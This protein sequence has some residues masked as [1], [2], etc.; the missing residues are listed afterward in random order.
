[1]ALPR[2]GR[3][4]NVAANSSPLHVVRSKAETTGACCDPTAGPT[5][6][7]RMWR[8]ALGYLDSRVI[9]DRA[10]ALQAQ[11]RSAH[12]SRSWRR[13]RKSSPSIRGFRPIRS[14]KAAFAHPTSPC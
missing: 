4:E 12:Q 5:G 3:D 10:R 1:L 7:N 9:D 11:L 14:R 6:P 13:G 2:F 8:S